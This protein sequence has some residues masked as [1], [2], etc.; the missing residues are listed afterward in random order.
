[1]LTALALMASGNPANAAPAGTILPGNTIPVLRGLVSDYRNSATFTTAPMAGGAGQS[2]TINQLQPK[3]ILNWNQFNIGNGS[4]V[5]F[6]QPS[7]TAAV[8]NRIFDADPSIIQGQIKA[9]GQVFLINQN[10][11]LF[12][13]GTQIDVNTLVASSM[14]I[15]NDRFNGA[16]AELGVPTTP[17][18]TGGYDANGVTIA[19][20]K[21]GKIVI[22]ANGSAT[23]AVP[24]INAA[25]GGAVVVIAPLIDNQ[26]GVIT[27]P[28]GQ[29]VLA[30]GRS[31]YLSYSNTSNSSLRGMLVEVSAGS[32]PVDLSSV[33]RNSGSVSADRGNVTLAALAINQSGRVSATSATLANGSIYLQGRDNGSTR[34]GTVTLAAGSLTDTPLDTTDKTTLREADS[35][36]AFRPVVNIQAASIIDDGRIASPSGSVT[37]DAKDPGNP[38]NARIYLG[39]GSSIDASGAWSDASS[40]SNLL[41]FKVTSNELKDSPD[42]K[43]GILRGQTV[44]VDLRAGSSLLDL[45]GYQQNQARSLAQKAATGGEVT[46]STTGDL[47]QRTDSTI[48]VSGGGVRYQ[49]AVEATT[50]LIGSDG[51][52]YDIATAPEAL[53]YVAV[54]D[55]FTQS[56][57]RWGY[58]QSFGNALGGALKPDY[59]QGAA[60]GSL[61][62][63]MGSG[64][65]GLVLDGALRGGVTV[66][67]RQLAAA[68]RGATLSIGSFDPVKT[69]QDFG[70]GDVRFAHGVL[71][72]L[73]AG[74]AADSALGADRKA[75][76]VLATDVFSA[77]V[78]DAS[79]NLV[80]TGF[81]TLNLNANGRIDV[82]VGVSV[83]GPVGG[84]L[85][86]RANQIDVEGRIVVP[87][88]TVNA[89]GVLTS[90][91]GVS[92]PA[93]S[94]SV[95]SG[96][97]ID[98]SGVW[99][100]NYL[101]QAASAMPTAVLSSSGVAVSTSNGGAI[102]LTGR[103]VD[104]NALSTLDVS[105]G[106]VVPTKASL[107]GGAAGAIS[108]VAD[109]T[110]VASPLSLDGQLLGFGFSTGGSLSLS[111]AS[112]VTIGGA[113]DATGLNFDA[114]FFNRGGFQK[115]KIAALRDLSVAAGAVIRPQQS[116]LQLDGLQAATLPSGADPLS[117]ATRVVLPDNLRKPTS[118]ALASTSQL[119]LQT[120]SSITTDVGGSVSLAGA[121]GVSIDGQITT[122][123]GAISV[124]VAAPDQAD[125]PSLHLG[126]NGSLIARGAFTAQPNDRQL[127]L[128][129]LVSGGSVSLSAKK[130]TISLDEGSVIDVSGAAQAI[131]VPTAA[132]SRSPYERVTQYSNAGTVSLSGNDA[133]SLA[134]TI[135]G[136]AGG[137][138]AAGGSFALS[139]TTR[140]DYFD[141]TSSRRIVLT[142]AGTPV[143]ALA[144]YTDAAVSAA[145]LASGGFDKLRLQSE[146][147][148]AFA[149]DANLVAARGITL[150]SKVIEVADYA[151][152]ELSGASV[153]L[154]NSFGQRSRGNPG[155]PTDPRTVNDASLASLPQATRTGTGSLA[156]TAGTI[157]IVG[158]VTISGAQ[159]ESLVAHDD[160]RLSGRLVGNAGTPAGA[161]LSGSLTSAGNLA[162]S[163]AQIYPTT[164]SSFKIAVADGLSGTPVA[165][166]RIDITGNSNARGD[167]YS[168]G[169]SLTLAA[170]TIAQ[171]GVLKAP[172]GLLELDAGK[173]LVLGRGSI[174]SVS[175]DGLVIPY[176]ETQAGVTWTYGATGS[177]PLTNALGTPPAKRIAL[178]SPS[179]NVQPGATVDV[180]G[181]GDLAAFEF[182]PG[183]TG[184]KDALIQP[185]TYAILPAAKLSSM[186]VDADIA[187]LQNLGFGA[188]SAVYN[189]VRIGPGGPVA[190]GDYVLLPGYYALLKGGYMVQL[191]NGSTY[192]NL[193]SGQTVTLAN[194]L[195]V[196]PGQMTAAGTDVVSA[197]TI[198]VVVRP[199]TDIPKLAGYT[200]T[201]AAY[202]ATLADKNRTAVPFLP[203]DGGQLSI[204]A[205]QNL[206]LNGNLL[207]KLP[208][209]AARSAEVDLAASKIALVDQVGRVGIAS[210]Y[211]QID[212]GSLSR[213]D[214]SI[215]IGGVRSTS[216]AG[217]LVTPSATD[218]VVANSDAT[219]LKAPELILAA[220][221]SIS[222]RS[223]SRIEGGGT[224]VAPGADL[225]VAD[226]GSNSG[227]LVRVA[228]SALV[229]VK[230]AHTDSTRGSVNVEAGATIVS[231]GS[232]TLDATRTTTSAGA[233][234]VAPGGGLSLVSGSVSLGEL[235]GLTGLDSGLALDNTQLAG[236]NQLGT[237]TLKSYS[238]ID[239]YGA[240]QVGSAGLKNLVLDGASITGRASGSGTLPSAQLAATQVM[241]LNSGS[242]SGTSVVADAFAGSLVVRSAQ[243]VVGAGDKRISGYNDLQLEASA[244]I[245]GAG[246]GTLQTAST[247]HLSAARIASTSGADQTWTA[248]DG[249][250]ADPAAYRAVTVQSVTPAKPLA[251]STALGSRLRLA[252]SSIDDSGNIVMKSG[253]VTLQAMG[254]GSGDGIVLGAGAVI[255]AGGLTKDFK[256][257]LAV[258]DAGRV[259]LEAEHGAV[260]LAAGSTISVAAAD[261]GGNAGSLAI[262]A[263]DAVLGGTLKGGAA[264]GTQGSYAMDVASLGD[265]SALNT[266]LNRAGFTESRDIRVRTGDVTVAA[267]DVVHAHH[268]VLAADAG[269][270]DVKG[271]LDASATLG[272]GSVEVYGQTV[273]LAAGA[274]VDASATSD[275]VDVQ[276]ATPTV[277]PYAN[278][279]TV[280]LVSQGGSLD[281]ES[282]AV[283]DVRAG[284]K[285]AAGAVLLR[286]PRSGSS[287]QA[288]LAG[289]VLSQRQPGDARAAVA[290]EGNRIYNEAATGSVITQDMID[291]YATDN[292]AF[293]GAVNAAALAAG[294][295]GDDGA[296]Q[297]NV[298]VRPA[299]EVR[300]AGDLSIASNWDLTGAGWRMAPNGS[301][302]VEA[303]SLT[304]RSGGNLTLDSASIGN[305]DHVLQRGATWN[306]ALA[307]GADLA[308]ANPMQSQS[309]SRLAAQAISGAAGAGDLVLD[310]QL[311]EAS[312]RTGTGNIRLSAGRDF[313]IKAGTDQN[314]GLPVVGVVYSA[315]QAAIAD[316]VTS[317]DDARFTQGGGNVRIAA[318]RDAIG[319]GDEWMTEWFRY[320]TVGDGGFAGGVWWTYRP[321]F[322]DGVAALGGGDVAIAAGRDIRNLS[323]WAPTA[324]LKAGSGDS[325]MLQVF[326]GGDVDLKAGGDVVGGQYLVSR[327][328][329]S[330]T[331]GGSVGSS[332][333][334]SQLFMMGASGDAALAQASVNLTAGQSIT[335][336]TIDSPA[337]LFESTP[338]G[339]QPSFNPNNPLPV[340]GYSANS[341]VGLTAL[342]GNVTLG[343]R[344]VAKATLDPGDQNSLRVFVTDPRLPAVLPASVSVAA[345][346]A[347]VVFDGLPAGGI[348]FPSLTGGL[349][350]LSGKGISG[351]NMTVSDADASRFS[352]RNVSETDAQ[353]IPDLLVTSVATPNRLIANNST[354][355]F[356]NDIVALGG[357]ITGATLTVPTRSRVWSAGDIL[358]PVFNLQ[359]LGVSDQSQVV[360]D[361]GSVS[362][363]LTAISIGGPGSL[364]IEAGQNVSL[365][366]AMPLGSYGNQKNLSL[367]SAYADPNK[368]GS[369]LPGGAEVAV[370]AGVSGDVDLTK[371]GATFD[372]LTAAGST[373]DTKA[374][375]DAVD[376]FFAKAKIHAGN[377]DSYNTS[378]Q[379]F[380]G[381]S[382]DLLAP[383]GN[384]TVGLTTP[385]KDKLIGLVTNA[386]GSIRSYLSGD[387]DINQGK[388]LTAQGGDILIY[389]A[390][391]SIDAGRGAKTSV[392]TPPPSRK[393]V[394]DSNGNLVGFQYT[395][396]VAVAGS[397]I[398]T[399]TSKPNGPTS[400]APPSGNIYLFAPSGTIDAGEAGIA[401]G[402]NIFIAAL[403]VLNADNISSA[404]TATGVPPTV[405]GSVASSMASS[406]A[407]TAAGASKDSD[408]AAQAAAA[409]AQAAAAGSFKPAILTVE[410]LGFGDKNCKETAKDC[411]GK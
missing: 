208:T 265:F 278:G 176:G 325:A 216:A 264:R 69:S 281:F 377:I 283:I 254:T 319:A 51:K 334:K 270:V 168:A 357:S 116:N 98:T 295:R 290:L 46:L 243:V 333:Q 155:D 228:N 67:A 26:S 163:A 350:V 18:F 123:G 199:N 178:K 247:M 212:A 62:I 312:V 349:H 102:N 344:P 403:T 289:Q 347:D 3:I 130:A 227:A 332:S 137:P 327:G 164:G 304:V 345:L 13:R 363:P 306:V 79:N 411:L 131:D 221:D 321:N 375:K 362:G 85:N 253:G 182:I 303:G 119:S 152:V 230:R 34:R 235:A 405:V 386:G 309:E 107:S 400:V 64:L 250:A 165:D 90:A 144:G 174:T 225:S 397:G 141:T 355:R 2:L 369:T 111:T 48:D 320:S 151:S 252:G 14:N 81:G 336:A 276:G 103:L 294:I 274:V 391:G 297:G 236:F 372:A 404:G 209:A 218:I 328:R 100:N 245:L 196:V 385:N 229:N 183:S 133:M 311:A 249:S 242:A 110:Q 408:S 12:D 187:L 340:L 68:P 256:G 95:A 106:G 346:S 358:N 172:I 156:V 61:Q 409:A 114:G 5:E 307:S 326:G 351:L 21:T 181:G 407:T 193:K 77:G 370:M 17:A 170:D 343:N 233:L 356:V 401:S 376:K 211:L 10:G 201:N 341:A 298:H 324:A 339:D 140:G 234:Q 143:D 232:V 11:I 127:V 352:I 267:A 308:A 255:D 113:G 214:A 158:S 9:N 258:A 30:A 329:G 52:V 185:N 142:Q 19:G 342:G 72:S 318:Q 210:D 322:H 29:V 288:T 23:A 78:V 167:V 269:A 108:L 42:Q 323:A 238:G 277:A 286:A 104:L 374:A 179:V 251:D 287:V 213:L 335:L 20:A 275:K 268:L 367:P 285:G 195:T 338:F 378:I 128:G 257:T 75:E 393:S 237:L 395:L 31:V 292:V 317:R 120:G 161:R 36:A 398:Q 66:G 223:G 313:V 24:K 337:S 16:L 191:V 150:D 50:R 117:V 135:A 87:A 366:T 382:I 80:S 197:Q 189:S 390:D 136:H 154:A 33:I 157:D 192:A 305:P 6:V 198:G 53:T 271:R 215:L 109:S 83:L 60:G 105:A 88:G 175:A 280:A 59:V 364:L 134:G 380:S 177:N 71:S 55:K 354:D 101:T 1:V 171:G 121:S 331:A 76:L 43:S 387:F 206:A 310:S 359:N 248:L 360:A 368:P 302:T 399:V 300:A 8:L 263:R 84:E 112:T 266:Q 316:P 188:D 379:S 314:T 166:G 25:T 41:K 239:L 279:G 224:R 282:G 381:N 124:A 96:A 315:G 45:S 200:T 4:K 219:S 259:R 261:Q 7:T 63:S 40:A 202:F 272:K 91:S 74:F 207:A 361:Q 160:L 410:V 118:L 57:P 241:L 392:T 220:T 371:L 44:T 262:V 89:T 173:S 184:S 115:F 149:S 93:Q 246:T 169:G 384:I 54:A 138:T 348:L 73:P 70:V 27:S 86:L 394:F 226:V 244:E 97:L 402:G 139:L 330:I 296:A 389:T 132:G 162:L 388:V 194:G 153:K 293:M 145:R 147:Q 82:P 299:V 217:L 22:G 373:H 39:A 205:T 353:V 383:G 146:D 94:V 65:N 203:V 126:S 56:S 38:G 47:I 222:V 180:S 365:G 15:S 159:R 240:A 231:S 273:R 35:F 58:S 260:Q 125:T 37:L 291:A 92:A 284:A 406:G 190:A 129:T 122:P 28:D 32:E 186:P 99:T 301:A 204:T 49:G 148:I 396:P